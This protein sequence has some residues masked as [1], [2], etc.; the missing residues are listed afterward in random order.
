MKIEIN[1]IIRRM[2]QGFTQPYICGCSDGG[3]YV[4][5]G[6]NTTK[7]QLAVELICTG[8]PKLDTFT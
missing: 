2:D 6:S 7:K 4:V 5:K 8:Q 1:Q 3:K